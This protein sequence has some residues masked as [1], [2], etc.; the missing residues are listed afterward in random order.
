MCGTKP[1][2]ELFHSL[3]KQKLDMIVQTGVN[4][5]AVSYEYIMPRKQATTKHI[6]LVLP[7]T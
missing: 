7:T 6:S 4:T 5:L 1:D 2:A 3:R